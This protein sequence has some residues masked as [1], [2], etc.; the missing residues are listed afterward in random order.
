[1]PAT[2]RFQPQ[3][4]ASVSPGPPPPRTGGA[5]RF[6]LAGTLG[7]AMRHASP[8]LVP[9]AARERV[10]RVAGRIPAAVTRAAYLECRLREGAEPVD[11]IFRVERAGAEILAGRNPAID[12]GRLRGP[13]WEPVAAL[14]RAW[15]DGRAGGWERV[16]H[17]WLELDLDDG[18]AP[19]APAVPRPSVFLALDDHATAG[20][21]AGA[22]LA[23]LDTLL[24]PL[25]PG[26]MDAATRARIRDV[27]ARRPPGAAVPYA[28]LM[29]SRARQAVR[30]YLS[31][32][33]GPAVPAL[34]NE[35]G[36]PEDEA[37]EAAQV[38]DAIHGGAAPPLGM[39]HLDVLEGALLPR[40]G[41]EYTLER[42][43]QLRGAL[44]ERAFVDRLVECGLCRPERRDALAA[45]PGYEVR[46]LR[47]ELWPSWLIRRVNCIKLVHEPGR[48]PQAKGYLLA[49]HQ[50]YLRG[51]PEVGGGLR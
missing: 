50:P 9:Q 19:D 41:L 37:R 1:M 21:D 42:R 46:T 17:L 43:A 49:F 18:A 31:R 29:L 11:L 12:P 15:L 5:G 44:A 48:G 13:G 26:G 23:L 2:F 33:E 51:R 6:P 34:L 35:V 36:W 22:L 45:W 40:L 24:A 38:L 25:A 30:V 10:I 20:M 3:D 14:C 7:P 47:H 4:A 27:L 8:A 39:L 28:G 32:V 16:R